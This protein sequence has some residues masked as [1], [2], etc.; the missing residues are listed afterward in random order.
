MIGKYD[1]AIATRQSAAPLN[2]L[3]DDIAKLRMERPKVPQGEV[4]SP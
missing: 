4:S 2:P 3:Y 1:E